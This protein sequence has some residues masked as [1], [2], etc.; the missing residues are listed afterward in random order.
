MYGSVGS[1]VASVATVYVS[2][3]VNSINSLQAIVDETE[4]V[5]VG[6]PS[7]LES[8]VREYFKDMPI[9]AE[10]VGCESHFRQFNKDGKVISGRVNSRDK[11]LAQVNVDY[12]LNDAIKLG[13]D[14]YT[15]DGNL[16]YAKWLYEKKG[17]DPWNASKPCWGKKTNTALAA[18]AKIK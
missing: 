3:Q 7:T 12:H 5:Y 11:G 13:F 10:I 17:T 14:I 1:Q 6:E 2:P 18:N 16:A 4:D 9:L 15:V 8:Y